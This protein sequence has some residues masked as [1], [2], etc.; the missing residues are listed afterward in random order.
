[1]FDSN[2]IA[3]LDYDFSGF[4]EGGPKGV[5]PEPSTEAISRYQL[6]IS[7]LMDTADERIKTIVNGDGTEESNLTELEKNAE[8]DALNKAT[9]ASRKELLAEIC[10]GSP[11]LEDINQLGHRVFLKFEDYVLGKWTPQAESAASS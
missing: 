2:D 6:A 1:M 8:I 9:W 11:A 7:N 4:W 5:V 10:Q 3:E